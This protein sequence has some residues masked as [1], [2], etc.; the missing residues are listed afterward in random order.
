MSE[1]HTPG[2]WHWT[3]HIGPH[4]S[5][6]AADGKKVVSVTEPAYKDSK[7]VAEAN[8]CLIAAAPELLAACKAA[9][10][11][12]PFMNG[13]PQVSIDEDTWNM[14]RAA[15]AKAE[16]RARRQGVR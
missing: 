9:V 14:M 16:G 15:I 2:P 7:G 12:A 6:I 10:A 3:D 5:V 4:V 1:Q 13:K 8:A 11:S